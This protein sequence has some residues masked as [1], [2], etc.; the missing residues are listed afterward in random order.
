MRDG[1]V[2]T[3][4]PCDYFLDAGIKGVAPFKETLIAP[5]KVWIQ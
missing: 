4:D 2:R 1:N 3:F 5:R